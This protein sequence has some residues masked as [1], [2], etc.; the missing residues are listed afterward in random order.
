MISR[1][2]FSKKNQ[3]KKAIINRVNMIFI[4]FR[5][6]YFVKFLGFIRNFFICSVLAFIKR[7]FSED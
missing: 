3:G 2:L 5:K 7:E 6:N 1:W 4:L